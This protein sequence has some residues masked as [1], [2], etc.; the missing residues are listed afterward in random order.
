MHL[1]S[2]I[3]AHDTNMTAF[4]CQLLIGALPTTILHLATLAGLHAW[5]AATAG[6]EM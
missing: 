2:R 4:H 3:T 1:L 5:L 6:C